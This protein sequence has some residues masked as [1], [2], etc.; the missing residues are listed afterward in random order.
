LRLW[1]RHLS[2]CSLKWCRGGNRMMSDLGRC[3]SKMS[4]SKWWRTW[5]DIRLDMMSDSKW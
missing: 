4:K 3:Q 5:I 1:I 2:Y